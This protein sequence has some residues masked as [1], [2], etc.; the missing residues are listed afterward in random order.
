MKFF[1]TLITD[2]LSR[3][4]Y[5]EQVDSLLNIYLKMSHQSNMSGYVLT[6]L[7]QGLA[8]R[9][10]SHQLFSAS[11]DRSVKIWNVDELAYIETL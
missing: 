8:F 5:F 6:L 3:N 7:L 11:H 9:I 2:C 10:G 4:S 1:N